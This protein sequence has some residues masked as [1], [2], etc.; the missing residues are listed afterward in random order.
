MR[1]LPP[2]PEEPGYLTAPV[3]EPVELMGVKKEEKQQ[4]HITKAIVNMPNLPGLLD[5]LLSVDFLSST[6][7][8]SELFSFCLSPTLF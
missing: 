8:T 7:L 4:T 3:I 1:F 2:K 6:K 5:P